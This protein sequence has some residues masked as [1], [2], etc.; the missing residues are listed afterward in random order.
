MVE[1]IIVISVITAILTLY[2]KLAAKLFPRNRIPEKVLFITGLIGGA[3]AEYITM[4]IIRH[5]TRH[6]SFMIGLPVMIICHI[7]AAGLICRF[8][9]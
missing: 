5:K 9:F 8:Y 3:A 2:D 6:K 4:K 7:I 1:Y